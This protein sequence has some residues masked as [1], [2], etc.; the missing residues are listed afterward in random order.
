MLSHQGAG[1]ELAAAL[2]AL[3]P[4][5]NFPRP[6][7]SDGSDHVRPATL[8]GLAPDQT[9]VLINGVR[10][11]IAS[12]VN[13][14]GSIGRG[15][16]AFDLNTIPTV[17]LGSVEIL[18]DGASAQYGAD[19]IAGVIN[20]RLRQARSGGAVSADFGRYDTTYETARGHQGRTDGDQTSVNGWVGMPL[21]KEGFLTLSGEYQVRR[22]TNRS[23]LVDAS[24]NGFYHGA[25]LGRFGD[26]EVHSSSVWFNAGSP[27]TATWSGYAYGGLQTRYD[28]SAATARAYN[29]ANNVLAIYPSGFLPL[30]R[31][32]NRDYNLYSGVKGEAGGFNWDLAVG[33]GDNTL[34]YRTLN[35]LNRSY[36]AGS[37]TEFY[38][39]G[40][41][42]TQTTADLSATRTFDVGQAEPL[43]FAAGIGARREA[44][45]IH[46]G[47]H[48]SYD[49]G[50]QGGGLG[51]QGFGGF[52][53]A[54]ATNH[55]RTSYSAY[56]DLEGKLISPLSYGLAARYENYSDFG[57]QVTGKASARWDFS[58]MFAVRGAISNGFKAPALQQQYF[59]YTATNLVTTGAGSTLIQSGKLRVTDPAAIALGAK[60]LKP[61]TSVNYSLGGVF[62]N[63]NFQ[64][65]VDGY[66]I[67]ITDRITLSENLGV[68]TPSQTVAVTNAVAALLAPYNISA[69][70]FFL[71]GVDTTTQGVDIIAHYRMPPENWGR[72]DFTLAGN[73]NKT[74]V[75]KVPVT[76]ATTAVG[77]TAGFLFDRGNR[78]AYEKGQP[79]Q[80][81]VGSVDW[82]RKGVGAM[83]KATSYDSV[84]VPNNNSTLDYNT[85]AAVIYDLEIRYVFPK[86][87]EA[88]AG[89]NNLT[90][91]YPN[92]T[93]A[94]INAPTGS[95]GF[96]QFSPYGFN[97]RFMYARLGYKF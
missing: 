81:I 22:P 10:G 31:A 91:E 33:Y 96:P 75:T 88:A 87:I 49:S 56:V 36:G 38:D 1:T 3:A 26:P 6:A 59:S 64:L 84:L 93:P 60:P 83:F 66:H 14:N 30:I 92:A 25:V 37:A 35:T 82:F 12:L 85:G 55:S 68:A 28:I 23:D 16:T 77:A 94:N 63:G 65:T 52:S 41:G 40:F 43:N 79:E 73:V 19:A 34:E 46:A 51:A 72:Y 47:E 29:N 15:S 7:I 11:H 42:F 13:V 89:V 69:A 9:L 5:I 21:G 45:E 58:P 50:G 97:G 4:S 71:N 95:V 67:D 90:D 2:A 61:E 18:R 17:A 53:P 54:N 44:Y 70:Q 39:G 80:K 24:I 20:L 8:R 78:L 76:P 27:L 32:G 74:K 86:G 57:N 48:A 62:R